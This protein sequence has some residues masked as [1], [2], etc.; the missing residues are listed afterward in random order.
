MA[1][2]FRP[3]LLLLHEP[4]HHVHFPGG[5]WCTWFRSGRAK[6]SAPLANHNHRAG[7]PASKTKKY[8]TWLSTPYSGWCYGIIVFKTVFYIPLWKKKVPPHPQ[9]PGWDLLAGSRINYRRQVVTEDR[10]CVG[11]HFPS[12]SNGSAGRLDTRSFLPV[13]TCETSRVLLHVNSSF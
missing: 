9:Y 4:A 10:S 11:I 7:V 13:I 5:M 12:P 6:A 2:Y 3:A 1:S 8:S